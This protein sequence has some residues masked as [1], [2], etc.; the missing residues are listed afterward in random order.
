MCQIVSQNEGTRIHVWVSNERGFNV[1]MLE[2]K[3]KG[4]II[5]IMWW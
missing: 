1:V 3:I 5:I 4:I 2:I